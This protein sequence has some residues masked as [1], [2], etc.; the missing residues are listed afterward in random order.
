MWDSSYLWCPVYRAPLIWPT[1][2]QPGVGQTP[3]EGQ[4]IGEEPVSHTGTNMVLVPTWPTV[5]TDEMLLSGLDNPSES[6][7]PICLSF[8]SCLSHLTLHSLSDLGGVPEDVLC[9][10]TSQKGEGHW[11]HCHTRR[12]TAVTSRRNGSAGINTCSQHVPQ[13]LTQTSGQSLRRYLHPA[14]VCVN[15][16]GNSDQHGVPPVNCLQFLVD[17]EPMRRS[18]VGWK[19][20]RLVNADSSTRMEREM[21]LLFE[22]FT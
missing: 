14:V 9:V 13:P 1:P 4:D 12:Q 18:L 2:L 5:C 17:L 10:D 20:H 19:G 3:W 16:C 21:L 15:Y 8:V 22:K 6:F 7:Q 11:C